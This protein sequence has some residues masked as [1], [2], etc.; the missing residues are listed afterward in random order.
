[1]EIQVQ[2]FIKRINSEEL[3]LVPVS[4]TDELI[5]TMILKYIRNSY[6]IDTTLEDYIITSVQVD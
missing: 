1:M 4:L 3:E 6:G 5:A 2:A